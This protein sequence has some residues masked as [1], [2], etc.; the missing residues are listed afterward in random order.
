MLY[1]R[2]FV[3]FSL[4]VFCSASYGSQVNTYD[5]GYICSNHTASYEE[6]E[7]FEPSLYRFLLNLLASFSLYYENFGQ[8]FILVLWIY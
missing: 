6:Y 1:L 5:D 8:S 7:D 3:I 2:A 4:L